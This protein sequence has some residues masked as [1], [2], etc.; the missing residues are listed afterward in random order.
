LSLGLALF[1]AG[2]FV[3]TWLTPQWQANG[4]RLA[5]IL[6]G[7][8]QG[9]FLV[10]TLFFATRDV[11]PEQGPTAAALFNLSRIVGQTFG[12]GVVS[13]LIRYREDFHSAMLVESVNNANSALAARFNGLVASFLATNGDAALATKQAWASLSATLS[14]QAYVLAFADAF[15]IVSAVLGVSA[16]LVLMLPQL[17]PKTDSA[18]AV[19]AAPPALTNS[20]AASGSR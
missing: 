11:K 19:T 6:V 7:A 5:L 18:E 1:A 13:A 3:A 4:F 8:G 16:L 14:N 12:I 9:L 15:V 17:H 20:A 2:A 10:P